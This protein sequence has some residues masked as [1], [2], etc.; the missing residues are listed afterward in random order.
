MSLDIVSER[1]IR[2]LEQ[3]LRD[4]VDA[5]PP[6]VLT[7]AWFQQRL[8]DWADVRPRVSRQAPAVCGR[9]ANTALHE[10]RR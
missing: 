9:A 6:L 8:L 4:A 2:E 1:A 3:R 5:H 10:S 7:P